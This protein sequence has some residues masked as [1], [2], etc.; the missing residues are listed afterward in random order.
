MISAREKFSQLGLNYR[1]ELFKND[2]LI[3][4]KF[5]NNDGNWVIISNKKIEYV[6][7]HQNSKL[8][9]EILKA[10]NK[11]IEELGWNN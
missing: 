9:L 4:I 11:Q 5:S 6:E 8:P 1:T 2:K 3:E 7:N 10:I